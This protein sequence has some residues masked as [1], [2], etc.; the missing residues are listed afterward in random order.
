MAKFRAKDELELETYRDKVRV[1]RSLVAKILPFY[2][3][4]H[5]LW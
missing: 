2:Q 5:S 1:K 4:E 3:D